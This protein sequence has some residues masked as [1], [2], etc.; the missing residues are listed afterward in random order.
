MSGLKP[1]LVELKGSDRFLRLLPG[2]PV[3]A[4]MKSGYVT[5]KPGESV[6]EHKTEAKEESIIIFEGR[7][8]VIV[9][10]KLMFTAGKESLVYI[11]P[12][13][14]HDIRNSSDGPL[15]YVYVVAPV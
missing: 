1:V 4:G 9:E 2:A 11:P 12:E 8:E 13:T 10:G 3:T 14:N 6:G 5:L 15:R 7:A